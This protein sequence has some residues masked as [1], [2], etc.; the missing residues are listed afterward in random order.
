M[1]HQ[2]SAIVKQ[3]EDTSKPNLLKN[4]RSKLNFG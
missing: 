3:A 4:I 1:C 2:I